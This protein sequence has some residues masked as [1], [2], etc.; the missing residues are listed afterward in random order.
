M[1]LTDLV[2]YSLRKTRHSSADTR[3]EVLGEGGGGVTIYT[4]RER[5]R[6]REG[7]RER[8][9]GSGRARRILSNDAIHFGTS[10]FRVL[11]TTPRSRGVSSSLPFSPLLPASP[12]KSRGGTGFRG[13]TVPAR[14]RRTSVKR[15]LRGSCFRSFR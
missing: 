8:G 10:K 2:A 4:E 7:G 13:E 1:R 5:E 6:E 3:S 15:R 9:R 12:P 14:S 11:I